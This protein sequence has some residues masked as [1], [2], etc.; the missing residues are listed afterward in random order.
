VPPRSGEYKKLLF[1]KS[2]LDANLGL[3][4]LVLPV[5]GSVPARERKKVRSGDRDFRADKMTKLDFEGSRVK[6]DYKI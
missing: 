1:A 2:R 5:S 4:L 6:S 3:A